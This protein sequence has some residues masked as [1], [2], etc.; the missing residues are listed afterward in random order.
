MSMRSKNITTPGNTRYKKEETAFRFLLKGSDIEA[1]K[2]LNCKPFCDSGR[3]HVVFIKEKETE[4]TKNGEAMV[5]DLE[6]V[7]PGGVAEMMQ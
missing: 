1:L 3:A 7:A 2:A 6:Q 5:V 4:E